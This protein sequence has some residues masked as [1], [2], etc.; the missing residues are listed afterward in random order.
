[1]SHHYG[2]LSRPVKTGL[3]KPRVHSAFGRCIVVPIVCRITIAAW[4]CVI[5]PAIAAWC[6]VIDPVIAIYQKCFK[7]AKSCTDACVLRANAQLMKPCRGFAAVETTMEEAVFSYPT[8]PHDTGFRRSVVIYCGNTK[9][10]N[11][12]QQSYKG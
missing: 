12:G 2:L 10:P 3:A 6:C 4:C 1:M 8:T 5:D 7:E 9:T 11:R